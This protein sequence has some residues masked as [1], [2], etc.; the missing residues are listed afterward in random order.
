LQC[1]ACQH[2]N[3]EG[4]RFCG[5]CGVPLAR[6]TL[7]P[8]CGQA[9]PPGQRFCNQC[10]ARL[11]AAGS[12]PPARTPL[13]YTPRHLARRILTSRAALEGERKRVTVLFADVRH[14]MALSED[15]DPEA[16]HAILERYFEILTEG[17]HRFEGTVN[18]YTGDGIMALFG[19]PL[20]HEDHA[21]RACWAALWLRQPLRDWADE[22]RRS[23]GLSCSVRMGLHSG[24][25]VVGKIGDDLRMDYTARGHTVGLAARMEQLAEPGSAYL[26]AET[27]RQVEGYFELRDL[28]AFT[29]KGVREPVGVFELQEAGRVRTRLD[30][31]QA[32][33]FS[34]FVGRVRE[35]EQLDAAL[36]CAVDGSGQILGVVGPAGVGK[37]RLCH[38]FTE[39]CTSRG[40][41]VWRAHCPPH[42]HSVPMLP[43]VELARDYFGVGERDRP[44]EAR[45]RIAGTLVLL[46]EAFRDDLTMAF[47]MARFPDPE[48][49]L[50]PME[51]EARRRRLL[52]FVRRLLHARSAREPAVLLFDDLHWID[53]Q[54]DAFL[55]E[56][57]DLVG[58]TRTLLLV[59]FRPEY[60][61]PWMG[62]SGYQQI[63]LRP[64]GPQECDDLLRDLLGGDPSLDPIRERVRER[65]GGNPFFAEE[66]V[67]GLE[68]AGAFEGERGRYR[69]ARDPGPLA[70]P[71]TVHG[72]LAARIDRLAEREKR[73]LQAAAV[74]GREFS[75][76]VLARVVEDTGSEL[77]GALDSLRHAEMI[78]QTALYPIAEY[79]F[80]HPL[81]HEVALG[82]QLGERRTRSHAVVARA[83]EELE[84][85]RLDEV[86]PLVAHHWE[87]AGDALQAA[88]WH[89]RAASVAR[90]RDPA[91]AIEHWRRV[92]RLLADRDDA[93][94]LQLRAEACYEF[95]F[96]SWRVGVAEE[97]WR[98]A[99]REG[100]ELGRAAG[101]TAAL[102]RLLSGIAALRG[103]DGE[104][105]VQVELLEEALGL[106][107]ESGDFELEASLYQRIGWAHQLAGDNRAQLEWTERG[108]RFC[109][110][111]PDRAGAVSGFGTWA[112]LI[113][114]R[115]WALMSMGRF[116]QAEADL[117][118]G[119]ALAEGEKDELTTAYAVNGLARIAAHR[120]DLEAMGRLAQ[121]V[122]PEGRHPTGMIQNM[123][124]ADLGELALARGDPA[125]AVDML[126]RAVPPDASR[127]PIRVFRVWCAVRLVQAL[128]ANGDRSAAVRE[129][130]RAEFEIRERPELWDSIPFLTTELA[131]ARLDV[132]G[133][134]AAEGVR[135]L[136]DRRIATLEERGWGAYLPDALCARARG[137]A[138]LGDRAAARRDLRVARERYGALRA[139]RRVAQVDAELAALERGT[140]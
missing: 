102:A 135:E 70:L 89:S 123:K 94:A 30:R 133:A 62:R 32:R 99:Y 80:K 7:C 49:P 6:E 126:E 17:V 51:P 128:H 124:L 38:E 100:R 39:R 68:E 41:P 58:A 14:S 26:T 56:L 110:D 83:L 131:K 111:R 42:G 78:H 61:A 4:A 74:I 90:L 81:T 119:L 50:P 3:P 121:Q 96:T 53:E 76:P 88:R 79:A 105:R 37:S 91:S 31:S 22:L 52:D 112:W 118:R 139:P 40:I 66:L 55:G 20:A 69:L 2:A 33:G 71:E 106:A 103:F 82:S 45:R 67:T 113:S 27:A 86:A 97:E 64:L 136:L 5:T 93:D 28:G 134:E 43:V 120:Q 77:A 85:G 129:L 8:A 140:T 44:E 13:D 35:L 25:V 101:D 73:V 72:V 1:S 47:E 10:G 98:D 46:D 54:S 21:Q 57:V 108:I 107:R 48:R 127:A 29:V 18:Q 15:L 34:R 12:E 122:D 23:R 75:E 115:G 114:Q 19:A 130:D 65:S 11:G 132:H 109:Q 95:L 125:T 84:A 87:E 116:E 16:W 104:H 24:E 117:Q 138:L 9:N 59:N 63:A 60:E 137:A 36:A 92:R